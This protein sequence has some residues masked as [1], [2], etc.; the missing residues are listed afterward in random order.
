MDQP[1]YW[2]AVFEIALALIAKFPE[3]DLEEVSLLQIFEWTLALPN[4]K[5]DP[6]LAND[7]ILLSIYQEWYEEKNP[8]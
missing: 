6:E 4:F 5:D 8:I 7:D 2:D 3:E 1:L